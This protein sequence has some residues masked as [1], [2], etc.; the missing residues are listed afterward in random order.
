M[1][2]THY[3]LETNNW[4]WVFN[5]VQLT[6]IRQAGVHGDAFISELT[7]R[8]V[9]ARGRGLNSAVVLGGVCVCM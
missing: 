9:T 8:L 4:L 7:R 2:V 1:S 5:C 3:A 6:D